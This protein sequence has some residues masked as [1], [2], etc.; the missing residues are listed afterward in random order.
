MRSYYDTSGKKMIDLLGAIFLTWIVII[1]LFYL[2]GFIVGADAVVL[3]YS[4]WFGIS[5][6]ILLASII[7]FRKIGRKYL[8]LGIIL[9]ILVP[10]IVWGIGLV[11]VQLLNENHFGRLT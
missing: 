1:G 5:L 4:I 9:S 3:F 11:I 8:S 7:Y 6:I 10:L 2:I